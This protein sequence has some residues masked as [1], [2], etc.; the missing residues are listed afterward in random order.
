VRGLPAPRT[1]SLPSPARP[2]GNPWNG[3][4]P[5]PATGIR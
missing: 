3:A 2:A 5:G 4:R 1:A